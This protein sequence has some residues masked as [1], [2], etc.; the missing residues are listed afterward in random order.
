MDEA[1]VCFSHLTTHLL[2]GAHIA[3][4]FACHRLLMRGG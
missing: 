4:P 2:P 3:S 1:F